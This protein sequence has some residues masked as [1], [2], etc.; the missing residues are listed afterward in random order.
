MSK[1][2]RDANKIDL[3]RRHLLKVAVAGLLA[4]VA[5]PVLSHLSPTHAAAT[6]TGKTKVL[7]IYYS[8]SGNTREIANQIHERVGGD[9]IE[10]QTVEPYPDEYDAVTKQAKQELNSGYKPALKTKVESVGSYDVIFVG[11]PNWWGTIAAPVKT[12]LSEYDLSGK[13]IVPFITHGGSGLGRSVTD[14]SKLCPKSSVLDGLA[15][16]GRDAKTAQNQV[17]EWVRKIKITK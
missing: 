5:T 7:I 1:E 16:W 4:G 6:G 15:V 13:T 10:L 2:T 8:R 12:F 14:I 3:S 9:I 17:S 11:S